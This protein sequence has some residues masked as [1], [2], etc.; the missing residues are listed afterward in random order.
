ML[1]KRREDFVLYVSPVPIRLSLVHVHG[2]AYTVRRGNAR[3][4]NDNRS[5]G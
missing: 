1:G 3:G 2:A 4:P 5:Y